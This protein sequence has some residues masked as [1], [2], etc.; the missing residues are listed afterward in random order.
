MTRYDQIGLD[1][2]ITSGRDAHGVLSAGTLDHARPRRVQ[3]DRIV[4]VADWSKGIAPGCCRNAR[5]QAGDTRKEA[6]A[7]TRQLR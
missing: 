1:R 6:G 7:D 2:A 3:H 4:A 5:C